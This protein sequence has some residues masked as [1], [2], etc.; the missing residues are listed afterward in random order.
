MNS[1]DNRHVPPHLI[2]YW[3]RMESLELFVLAGLDPQS[4]RL[5]RIIGGLS[6][7][8]L[9]ASCFMRVNTDF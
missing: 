9:L 4:S 6:H 5:Y 1:W 7:C 8:T 2:F 3:L